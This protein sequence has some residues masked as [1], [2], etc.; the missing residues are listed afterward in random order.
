MHH[1]PSSRH[2][3]TSHSRQEECSF[4]LFNPTVRGA[5]DYGTVPIAPCTY[6]E[7]VRTSDLTYS[8]SPSAGAGQQLG[9][10]VLSAYGAGV[11]QAITTPTAPT[12]AI[13]WELRQGMHVGIPNA[14]SSVYPE[15]YHDGIGVGMGG[16]F[17]W[18]FQFN[19]TM[20]PSAFYRKSQDYGYVV[21]EDCTIEITPKHPK[22]PWAAGTTGSIGGAINT[23]DYIVAGQAPE[24]LGYSGSVITGYA[25]VL[26]N[27]ALTAFDVDMF[28][29]H[30]PLN[31]GA[32]SVHS[33]AML[34]NQTGYQETQQLAPVAEIALANK[35]RRISPHHPF[36][37]TRDFHEMAFMSY[38]DPAASGD[39]EIGAPI[40]EQ[41]GL[42]KSQMKPIMIPRGGF[43]NTEYLTQSAPFPSAAMPTITM[44]LVSIMIDTNKWT[45]EHRNRGA[46]HLQ[47]FTINSDYSATN[48]S[49]MNPPLE[50][51]VKYI[52]RC[53]FFGHNTTGS[54]GWLGSG[55]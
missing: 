9:Y 39:P 53:R 6:V 41:M 8:A 27:P 3:E 15:I 32:Y 49:M 48:P 40:L 4:V 17:V 10:S 38:P 25:P 5:T 36:K 21:L 37:Y 47:D 7:F 34:W 14:V 55:N 46:D 30:V 24:A 19:Q 11:P 22:A 2:A 31:F 12:T 20:L 35:W 50:W 54:I 29:L 42:D 52:I 51:D 44:P 43:Q 33:S 23:A 13:P 26:S 1:H 28:A 18:S 45:C 16:T